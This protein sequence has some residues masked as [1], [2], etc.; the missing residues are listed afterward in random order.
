MLGIRQLHVRYAQATRQIYA[1]YTSGKVH[2]IY[3][4]F[5]PGICQEVATNISGTGWLNERYTS[6]IRQVHARYTSDISVI[7]LVHIDVI[8]IIY[9]RTKIA[10]TY[11][12]IQC[13]QG[14]ELP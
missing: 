11:K 2:T 9:K 13:L 6:G 7:F 8:H 5:T 10:F 12:V 14:M 3:A 1:S 4:R